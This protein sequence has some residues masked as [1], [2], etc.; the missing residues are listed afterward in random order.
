[1]T[2]MHV[3]LSLR[4]RRRVVGRYTH[5]HTRETIGERRECFLAS[6][7]DLERVFFPFFL[8]VR[9][10]IEEEEEEEP[11]MERGVPPLNALVG[12]SSSSSLFFFFFFTFFVCAVS[13]KEYVRVVTCV[14]VCILFPTNPTKEEFFFGPSGQTQMHSYERQRTQKPLGTRSKVIFFSLEREKWNSILLNLNEIV[15]SIIICAKSKDKKKLV[16]EL[17]SGKSRKIWFT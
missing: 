12:S 13:T 10:R 4:R 17:M 8:P 9:R 1:M 3:I 6:D 14:C 2:V 7:P 16:E 11:Y 15:R 5:R